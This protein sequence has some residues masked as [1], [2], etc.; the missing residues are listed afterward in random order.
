MPD[1]LPDAETE[2]YCQTLGD[3]NA[4]APA[5]PLADKLPD[6]ET[7][8]LGD[9]LVDVEAKVLLDSWPTS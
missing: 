7:A 1:N 4:T 2:A 3:V 9:T 5:D 8:T 6:A